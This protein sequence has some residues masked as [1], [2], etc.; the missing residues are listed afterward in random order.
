M[1]A[2][3][4]LTVEV[5]NGESINA[6]LKLLIDHDIAIHAVEQNKRSLKE[7]IKLKG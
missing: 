6:I 4:P 1:I 7:I 2:W 3:H 5:N